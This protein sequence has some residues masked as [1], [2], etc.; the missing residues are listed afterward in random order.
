MESARQWLL[1]RWPDGQARIELP[2]AHAAENGT[3]VA[4][5]ADLVIETT[6][7]F[8]LIDY[9]STS[10]ASIQHAK[11]VQDHG[12]QLATYANI[13]S[14]V[15]GKPVIESWLMLPMTGIALRLGAI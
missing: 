6:A 15:T 10:V 12:G 3:M 2:M 8:I 7:G 5:R 13:L 9:K 11:L 1:R 4:G 14:K